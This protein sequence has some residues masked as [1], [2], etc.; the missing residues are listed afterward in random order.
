M[1]EDQARVHLSSIRVVIQEEVKRRSVEINGQP[2]ETPTEPPPSQEFEI[3]YCFFGLFDGHAGAG[4]AVAAA[5]SLH[6][7]LHV[8]EINIS[9]VSKI[10]TVQV[11]NF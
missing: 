9:K 2:V 11:F 1:N 8:R 3:P 5:A 4:A 7:I 10:E 6:L